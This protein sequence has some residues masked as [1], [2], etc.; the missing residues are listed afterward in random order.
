MEDVK[1]HGNKIYST[2][3]LMG[4]LNEDKGLGVMLSNPNELSEKR[5]LF[6]FIISEQIYA[7]Q[8]NPEFDINTLTYVDPL[9]K[10]VEKGNK[11]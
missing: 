2:H 7:I 6:S 9:N 4:N 8:K 3:I 11:L 1:W 5:K 10:V